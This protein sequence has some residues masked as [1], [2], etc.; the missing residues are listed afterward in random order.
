MTP[1]IKKASQKSRFFSLIAVLT[2]GDRKQLM[3]IIR[4]FVL[5]GMVSIL[6]SSVPILFSLGIDAFAFPDKVS[7]SV[8]YITAFA[9]AL[10]VTSVIDQMGSFLFG[11]FSTLLLRDF[12]VHAFNH[13]LSLPY[14]VLRR[15]TSHEIAY[16]VEQ[17][18][19]AMRQVVNNLTLI[20]LPTL[21]E[22]IIA[23]SVIGF[24]LDLGMG[25]TLA[26]VLILYGYVANKAADKVQQT[27]VLAFGNHMKV[28][29]YAIDAVANASL[30][31]Q[32]NLRPAIIGTLN[33]RLTDNAHY[34]NKSFAQRSFYGV[35]QALIFGSLVTFILWRSASAVAVGALTIG[36]LVLINTYIV[37]LLL[38]METL[39]RVYREI[40]ASMGQ[41]TVLME[42][43]RDNPVTSVSSRELEGLASDSWALDLHNIHITLEETPIVHGL[44]LTIPANKRLFMVGPSGV[45]KTSLLRLL[46]TLMPASQG[47]YRINGVRVTPEAGDVL[48][49]HIAMVQQECFL[50]DTTLDENVTL[51]L[52]NVSSEVVH[53][54]LESLSLT[55][56]AERHRQ[57]GEATVGERGCNLSGGEKQRI[58]LARALLRHPKLLLIDEPTSALDEVTRARVIK[59]LDERRGQATEVIVTHDIQMI[60]PEDLVLF[61]ANGATFFMGTHH[62]VL[63]TCPAYAAFC[64]G[65][66]VHT[67]TYLAS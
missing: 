30:V 61:F 60:A 18:V 46:S 2:L 32:A 8:F 4:M 21:I 3:R 6:Q 20:I 52:G 29:K 40:H 15:R 64:R 31:Q 67:L 12:T 23:A 26:L 41:A 25:L 7:L 37:R 47:D 62:H 34:W 53:E 36:Q 24:I 59:V 9:L 35:L 58:A 19:E 14:H 17:G 27:T 51:G 54:V 45:G 10:M 49:E 55:E 66:N 16:A 1:K 63:A 13:A 65:E 48:R 11:P 33:T 43:L 39:A 57:M 38:P 44:S 42:L 28:W 5:I 56:V 50:L 22:L